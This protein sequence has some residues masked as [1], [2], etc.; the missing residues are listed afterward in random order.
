MLWSNGFLW[1][2]ALHIIFVICWFASIFYLPRLFVYHAMA[3]DQ[4]SKDRF[5]VMER[6]LYRAIGTPSMVATILFGA[7]TASY[8]WDYYAGSTWFWIKILL[9][10]SL[11]VYHFAC[12]RYIQKFKADEYTP[13]HVFFRYFNELPV[14]LLFIIVFLVV[15]KAPQ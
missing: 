11:V 13:K 1:I 3:E 7:W 8:N 15:V 2:K 6:K 4:I 5:K 10:G 12:G 9:V 14:I